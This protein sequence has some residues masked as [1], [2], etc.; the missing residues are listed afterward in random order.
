MYYGAVLCCVYVHEPERSLAPRL[1]PI[2]LFS[3]LVQRLSQLG[4]PARCPARCPALYPR[5]HLLVRVLVDLFVRRSACRLG[6][7][8]AMRSGTKPQMTAVVTRRLMNQSATLTRTIRRVAL[9]PSSCFFITISDFRFP[10]KKILIN[11][12]EF[13]CNHSTDVM[14]SVKG[15][16]SPLFCARSGSRLL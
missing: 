12:H 2:L 4:A 16:K 7:L 14:H 5:L 9:R 13:M 3:E 10:K 6:G 15:Y 8:S 1:L 11:N